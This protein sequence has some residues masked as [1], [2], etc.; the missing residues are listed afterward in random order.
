MT[1]FVGEV[2]LF[3]GSYVPAGWLPCD[4]QTLS[5][6]QYSTLYSVL[7]VTWGGNGSTTFR[8]P[9]LRGRTPLGAGTGVGL[10]PRTL[11]ETG[12]AEA[13]ALTTAE[14]P[15]HTHVVRG[16]GAQA[17]DGE[18]AGRVPAVAPDATPYRSGG[19]T[20]LA[21]QALDVTGQGQPHENRSPVLGLRFGICY[22]GDYPTGSGDDGDTT[23]GEIRLMAGTRLPDGWLV[24]DGSLQQISGYDAL[25]TILG[26]TYG[27]NGVQTFGVPDLRGRVPLHPAP[28]RPTGALGGVEQVTLGVAQLPV[29][30][31]TARA[32]GSPA[33]AGSP[34]GAVRA[35]SAAA[36]YAATPQVAGAP[37]ESTGGSVPHANMPP[38]AAMT[39]MIAARGVYPSRP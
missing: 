37:T 36:R 39:F 16:S 28:G 32:S 33:T 5:V 30:E 31:H 8:L 9:D 4:G 34:G 7:G 27:G 29:H 22:E 3:A 17:T 35:A 18:P 12:G 38:Y 14:M 23:L 13:V 6:S 24:C 11:G 26:T 21:P 10:T 25:Y 19:T 20:W 2:R 15:A 1:G